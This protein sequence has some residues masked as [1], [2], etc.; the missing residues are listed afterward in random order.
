[1]SVEK[2]KNLAEEIKNNLKALLEGELSVGFVSKNEGIVYL[3]EALKNYGDFIKSFSSE[4]FKLLNI[5][6]HSL[7]LSGI[8]LGFFKT[9]ESSIT[10]LAASG[11]GPVGQLLVFK[12]RIDLFSERI[13]QL[14]LETPKIE[15]PTVEE[16]EP[17]SVFSNIIPHI[18]DKYKKKKYTMEE[19]AVIHQIDGEKSIAEISKIA[20]I[21]LLKVEEIIR[22]YEKKKYIELKRVIAISD[23]PIKEKEPEILEN[24]E[25]PKQEDKTPESIPFLGKK[26]EPK[27]VESQTIPFSDS[28]ELEET[29][30]SSIKIEKIESEMHQAYDIFPIFDRASQKYSKDEGFYLELCDGRH[31]INDIIELTNI[32]KR[33]LFK[34]F[35]KFQKK[36]GLKL[37]RFVGKVNIERTE[38]IKKPTSKKLEEKPTPSKEAEIIS[39]GDETLDILKTLDSELSDLDLVGEEIDEEVE[40]IALPAAEPEE[41]D[42]P[43]KQISEPIDEMEANI[44]QVLSEE[45][46]TSQVKVEDTL[47]EL[48]S[49]VDLPETED[50]SKPIVFEDALSELDKLIDEA[51]EIVSGMDDVQESISDQTD[52]NS[53]EPAEPEQFPPHPILLETTESDV[54]PVKIK[55]EVTCEMC[56]STFP[57]SKRLCPSCHKPAKICPNCGQPVTVFAKICPYC[58]G[59]IN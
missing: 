26:E 24:L 49:L 28:A 40:T 37:L 56:G 42:T 3:D 9:S 12:S 33:S 8:R 22:K 51:T 6:D 50:E 25:R 17:P 11:E 19:A 36:D 14:I 16:E 43:T 47:D 2:L 21:P 53:D 44:E 1:M 27:P 48:S 18:K 54:M 59:L 34:I 57:T 23:A 46:P 39:S 20:E 35:R 38:P 52:E 45:P 10:I 30:P 41:L 55:N 58:T 31:S 13:E 4:N 15:T 32:D 29:R 7:P 5:Y